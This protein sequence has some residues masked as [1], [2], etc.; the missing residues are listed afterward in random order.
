MAESTC[1]VMFP[2]RATCF[3]QV[4]PHVHG[5]PVLRVLRLIRHLIAKSFPF[6]SFI[7]DRS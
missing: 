1:S 5:S 6:Y 2:L 4:L 3:R 7:A